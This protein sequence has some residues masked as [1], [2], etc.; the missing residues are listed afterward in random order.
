M[1]RGFIN[2]ILSF[3]VGENPGN[4]VEVSF[5]WSYWRISFTNS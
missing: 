2:L 5:E 4:E 1:E 3:W